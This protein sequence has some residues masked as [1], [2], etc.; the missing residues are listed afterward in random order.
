MIFE[1]FLPSCLTYRPP[2]KIRRALS[3][4]QI[5]PFDKGCV[6]LRGILGVAQCLFESPDSAD[7][8]SSLNF[9]NTIVSAG[10][11]DLAIQTRLP[12]D[13]AD[14]FRKKSKSVRGN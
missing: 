4:C 3:D 6:P 8:G 9:D 14:N 10:F 5:Q 12:K 13:T 7:H 11:N 1:T 2:A